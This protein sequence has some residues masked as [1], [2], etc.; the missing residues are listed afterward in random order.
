MMSKPSSWK[1][2][3][4]SRSVEHGTHVYTMA[5]YWYLTRTALM[6]RLLTSRK[7]DPVAMRQG[8]DDAADGNQNA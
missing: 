7:V 1:Q 6:C 8:R 5:V 2:W 4:R 3:W